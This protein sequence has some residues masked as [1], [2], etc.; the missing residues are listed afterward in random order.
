MDIGLVLFVLGLSAYLTVL[1]KLG[2]G[3]YFTKLPAMDFHATHRMI[4]FQTQE[5]ASDWLNNGL[6]QFEYDQAFKRHCKAVKHE[7][8]KRGLK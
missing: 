4:R 3:Y 6:T 2:W 8:K 5:T 7:I 1:I